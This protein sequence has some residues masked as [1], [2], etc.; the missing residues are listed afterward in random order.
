MA[1]SFLNNEISDENI[2]QVTATN[3]YH[4]ITDSDYTLIISYTGL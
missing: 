2:L 1:F 4:A 3:L